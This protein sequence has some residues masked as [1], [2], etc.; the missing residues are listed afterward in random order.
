M[1]RAETSRAET[2][3]EKSSSSSSLSTSVLS[4]RF[5]LAGLA[6]VGGLHGVLVVEVVGLRGVLVPLVSW[7]I[8]PLPGLLRLERTLMKRSEIARGVGFSAWS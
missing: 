7:E 5:L 1:S 6:V 4:L 8:M 3:F 2:W